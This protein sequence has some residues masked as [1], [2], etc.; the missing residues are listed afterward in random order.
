MED[1]EFDRALVAS[2]FRLAAEEGWRRVT[3]AEAARRAGLRL[4]QARAR[5]PVR[6]MVLLRFG[7]LADQAALA[8]ATAEGGPRDRLFDL[9]MRRF[10]FVQ[11]H[12]AGVLALLRHL[13]TDPGAAALLACDT[14]R[15]MGWMLDGAGI[16]SR[17]LR[18]LLRAKGLVAV[19]MWTMRTWQADESEDLG[20]TMA[21]LDSALRRAER[22]ER[23][24]HPGAAAPAP[25]AAP[26]PSPAPAF[27]EPP[28]PFAEPP[29]PAI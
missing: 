24:L 19:W 23:C 13:P 10:D 21:A 20:P 16:G 27:T 7:R 29:S 9:L 15:S 18:G 14:L 26:P 11:A 3:V 12:R 25:E 2:A 8:R 22:V 6:G 17:G 1:A 5:F 4:D 28:G